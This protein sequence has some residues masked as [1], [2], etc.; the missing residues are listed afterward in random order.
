MANLRKSLLITFLF[1]NG[2]TAVQFVVTIVLARLLSPEEIGI[3]SVTA[4]MVSM[5]HIFRDFGVT[6]F[7]Q[8]EKELTRETV[9]SAFGVLITS[10]WAIALAVFLASGPASRFFGQP[11]IESVMEVLALGFV[12]IP[13][14][15]IT[16]SLLIRD[17]RAQHQM[18]AYVTGTTAYAV[19]AI[20]LAYLGFGYMSMAWANLAN[21]VATALG[22]APYRPKIAP[23]LPRFKGWGKVV[24]FGAGAV[25]G[26][27]LHT[28]N[29][30]V[31]DML[32]GK[33]SGPHDVGIM[34][35]AM[36]T[37]NMLTQVL[38]P[39]LNYAVLPFLSKSHHA[40]ES[41]DGPLSRAVAYITSLMWP[42]LAFTFMY[43]D[44]IV[45]FLYGDQWRESIPVVRQVCL[46]MAMTV[47][48]AFNNAAY[49]A[50]G[51]PYLTSLPTALDIIL[52]CLGVYLLYDGSLASFAWALVASSLVMYPVHMGLQRRFLS[53]R[54]TLF[55]RSQ[56]KSI[57]VAAVCTAVAWMARHLAFGWPVA[58]EMAIAAV[59][60][61]ISWV[62][63]I[64]L[65][66]APLRHEFE[67]ALKRFP[68]LSTR[69]G[70][71]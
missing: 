8:R 40:G 35:R 60:G 63:A 16:H 68:S 7:L 53:I 34:G 24:N 45:L 17:Y 20:G 10:S 21:I 59:V 26:N 61:P 33:L 11:G 66:R 48:F 71:S 4:V 37:P 19:T 67:N 31:P 30:S 54:P 22:Y 51:R 46:M 56:L 43:A 1:S 29:N 32:L 6:S 52:R 9:G 28:V 15:S 69:L 65:L 2:A 38:G 39:T 70:L 57:A 27:G 12:F 64:W 44:A 41:L 42:A 23:W 25:L 3:F 49:M 36:S 55:L 62:L 13:F 50:I 58:A 14:G 47:P 18:L 5:A